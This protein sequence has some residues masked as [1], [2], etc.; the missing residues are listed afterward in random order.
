MTRDHT[1]DKVGNVVRVARLD[2]PLRAQSPAV[3][4]PHDDARS[5][6]CR[7]RRECRRVTVTPP[8]RT[9]DL[10]RAS[11]WK[12]VSYFRATR[13]CGPFAT[14]LLLLCTVTLTYLVVRGPA[15][16]LARLCVVPAAGRRAAEAPRFQVDV[17]TVPPEETLTRDVTL[18]HLTSVTV[19]PPRVRRFPHGLSPPPVEAGAAELDAPIR[20]TAESLER[21]RTAGPCADLA[22]SGVTGDTPFA[23]GAARHDAADLERVRTADQFSTYA[24]NWKFTQHIHY[25]ARAVCVDIGSATGYRLLRLPCKELL[26]VEADPDARTFSSVRNGVPTVGS[27]A[28]VR[29]NAVDVIVSHH[30]LEHIPDPWEVVRTALH[31]LKLGGVFIAVVCVPP[32]RRP[33]R[34]KVPHDEVTEAYDETDRNH[35]L[36]T[37]NARTLGNLFRQAGYRVLLAHTFQHTWV[38]ADLDVFRNLGEARFHQKSRALA[39]HTGMYQVRIIAMRDK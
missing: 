6:C 8:P 22:C 29:D 11:Q 14:C 9:L 21:V 7:G 35:H 34:G 16:P 32:V 39:V 31:K 13:P 30:H 26:G 4:P 24:D 23:R 1:I 27:I 38:T 19:D 20:L 12:A 15:S 36:Y 17:R 33:T 37:W 2:G 28:D 18:R 5:T 10:M 25:P 3:R